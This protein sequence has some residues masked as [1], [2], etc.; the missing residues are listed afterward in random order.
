V[1]FCDFCGDLT[2]VSFPVELTLP[3]ATLK[4]L[5]LNACLECY[6]ELKRSRKFKVA[7]I[8][9]TIFSVGGDKE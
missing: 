4:P 3:E 5:K 7:Q 6:A 8:I 2:L 9:K 1:K